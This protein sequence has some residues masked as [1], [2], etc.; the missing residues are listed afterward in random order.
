MHQLQ[1]GCQRGSRGWWS[2]SLW[3]LWMTMMINLHPN[4]KTTAEPVQLWAL[5]KAWPFPLPLTNESD[6]LQVDSN[7]LPVLLRHKRDF[8]ITAAVIAAIAA[9]TAAAAMALTTSVQTAATLNNVTG[10]V[11]EA[12]ATQDQINGHLH[13]GILIVNQR[14]D[15]VQEQVDILGSLLAIGCIRNMPG[16]C[17][18]PVTYGT[19]NLKFQNLTRQLRA[20]IVTLNATKGPIASVQDWLNMLQQSVSFLKQWAGLGALAILLVIANVF[21]IRWFC[22]LG[23]RQRRQQQLM[24]Q[25]MMALEAGTSPQV[26]LGMLDR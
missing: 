6:I 18:T 22:S 13:A 2:W 16:L 9:S 5:V 26:W 7:N 3:T 14:V 4:T 12:L 19:W 15:L 20:Q 1:S 25:A 8:G 17:V 11:A 23:R 24:A 21:M 10:L